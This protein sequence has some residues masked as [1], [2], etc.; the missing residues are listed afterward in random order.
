MS[1]SVLL[2][3]KTSHRP[4]TNGAAGVVNSATDN[5]RID[6]FINKMFT[7]A[8]PNPWGIPMN[9]DMLNIYFAE[10]ILKEFKPE[11]LVV[12]MQDVDVA[13][14][15]FTNYAD[16]L[17]KADYAVAHLWSTI[18]SIPGMQ[19]DTVMIIAPE[20]GR[21]AIGNNSIDPYGR[22]ALD[23]TANVDLSSGDQTAREIFCL[24]ESRQNQ[25]T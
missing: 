24:V 18:Q 8:V 14:F 7:T 3:L 17:R 5:A 20:H 25:R 6:Q 13:H 4:Y 16:N 12:N 15:N 21:N 11:L 23:H 19:N 22:E 10:E 9:N 1:R 2:K